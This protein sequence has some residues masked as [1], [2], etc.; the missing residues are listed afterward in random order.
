MVIIRFN[1]W[2]EFL[3]ELK[4]RAPEDRTIRLTFSQRYDGH[5]VPHLTLVAGCLDR[6]TIVEYVCYLGLQ[7]VDRAG[8]RAREIEALFQDRRKGLEE[9]GFSVKAGRYHVP[10]MLQR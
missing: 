6:S 7:P 4:A 9:L 3:D 5:N 1:H 10:P 2:Q 8:Q